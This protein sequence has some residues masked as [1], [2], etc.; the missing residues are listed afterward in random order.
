M[1][2]KNVDENDSE[3]IIESENSSENDVEDNDEKTR[4]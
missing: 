4:I 2:Y 1:L 3:K